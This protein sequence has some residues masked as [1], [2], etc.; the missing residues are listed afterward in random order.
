MCE[1]IACIGHLLIGEGNELL[2]LIFAQLGNIGIARDELVGAQCL[3]SNACKPIVGIALAYL[4]TLLCVVGIDHLEPTR[5]IA[6]REENSGNAIPH[7]VIGVF[8]AITL[9]T[10]AV[11]DRCLLVGRLILDRYSYMSWAMHI[12]H[13]MYKRTYLECN[14]RIGHTLVR[15]TQLVVELVDAVGRTLEYRLGLN[16]LTA[17]IARILAIRIGVA[18]VPMGS[19]LEW[20]GV[21]PMIHIRRL[22]CERM[23]DVVVTLLL[24][25]GRKVHLGNIA[26]D[27]V[28]WT[29]PRQCAIGGKSGQ[30]DGQNQY[31]LHI[32]P[33][34]KLHSTKPPYGMQPL[35]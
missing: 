17:A 10:I 21:T 29:T 15:G 19:T 14:Q 4:G 35:P 7:C 13:H 25:L 18:Y 30:R 1:T 12:T 24:R 23:V 6:L 28:A 3:L 16:N 2:A 26:D 5:N 20:L 11:V 33:I 22:I 9:Q 8:L 31:L 32:F 34:V 27:G